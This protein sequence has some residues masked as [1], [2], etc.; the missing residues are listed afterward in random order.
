[1]GAFDNANVCELVGLLILDILKKKFPFTNF[2]LFRDGVLPISKGATGHTLDKI[3]KDITVTMNSLGNKVTIETDLKT[4]DFLGLTID[5]YSGA[6]RPNE[7]LSYI[8]M[9]S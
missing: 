7:K 8:N 9:G 1:M 4:V 5:L 3:R 2:G 6:H